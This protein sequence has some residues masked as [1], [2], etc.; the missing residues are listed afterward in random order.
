[1]LAAGKFDDAA[2][3]FERLIQQEELHEE[4]YRSLMTCRARVGDRMA[5]MREYRRLEAVLQRELG[6]QP[7]RETAELFRRLQRGESV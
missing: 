3:V 2:S 7:G 5:A 1:M 4:G 6:A